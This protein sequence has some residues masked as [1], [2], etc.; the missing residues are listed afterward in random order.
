M[1]PDAEAGGGH[2][3]DGGEEAVG[4]E[5]GREAE[6]GRQVGKVLVE[7]GGPH[8]SGVLALSDVAEVVHGAAWGRRGRGLVDEV[9]HA[10][11][12]VFEVLRLEVHVPL[13]SHMNAYFYKD[14]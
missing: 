4:L 5:E 10:T 8:G 3:E 12:L 7:E 6:V 14:T 13:G 11:G 9:T 1:G 2:A